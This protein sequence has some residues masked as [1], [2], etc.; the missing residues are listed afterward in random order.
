MDTTIKARTERIRA[1]N[2][3]FRKSFTGGRVMLTAGVD[4][5]PSDVKAMAIRKVATFSDFASDNDPYGEHDFGAFDL[6]G[7]K[8][9]WKIEC[10]DPGL[11]WGSDDPADPEKT[12]RI[13]TLMLAEEY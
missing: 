4:A 7:R 3:A 9:F 13:L 6:A 1:L 10:Y 12:L 2:D 8:I 5:L 11:E